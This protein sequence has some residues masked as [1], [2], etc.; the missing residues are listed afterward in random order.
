MISS[1]NHY[2]I[3]IIYDEELW[4]NFLLK[5]EDLN[6]Y[7]LWNFP[8]Y[9]QGEKKLFHIAIYKED[10]LEALALVRIKTAPFINRGIAYI[11]RG[12][13]WQKINFKNDIET[14]Y[15]SV[16]LLINEFLFHRRH[17]LRI[18]PAIFSDQPSYNHN[19]LNF[20]PI[21]PVIKKQEKTLV[22][23]LT[24]NISVIRS[25]FS[26]KW[27]NR[28]NQAE[29]NNMVLKIGQEQK[30]FEIFLELY[31]ELR[32]RKKFKEYVN[33]LKIIEMNSKQD[34]KFKLWAFIAYKD[35]KPLS[36]IIISS[37]GSTG[38]YLLGATN[39]DGMKYK[40]SYL[41]QW[42]AIKWLQKQ[43]IKRYDLGGI[44][45]EK[46]PGVFEFK[47]GLTKKEVLDLGTLDFCDSNILRWIVFWGEKLNY[48]KFLK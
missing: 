11:Y 24:N 39:K 10:Q 3:E 2:R 46:N 13:L 15:K 9:A 45:Q 5:F 22:I 47:S 31:R 23:D 30:L 17:L 44:D 42:E 33:P 14:F 19:Y 40:A 43:G 34:V 21:I 28:L 4:N 1:E 35:E 41:L 29:K 8:R 18:K 7:Q 12:P 37:L 16:D 32:S 25:Q 27:R 38:I 20:T 36:A 6:I 48:G 26:S